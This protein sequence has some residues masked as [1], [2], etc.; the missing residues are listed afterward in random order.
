MTEDGLSDSRVT[1]GGADGTGIDPWLSRSQALSRITAA[2]REAGID[3][4]A[5]DARFLFLHVLGITQ[6]ELVLSGAE[7]LGEQGA[8]RL[9]EAMQRRL[10][11]EP[12]A[13]I[14]G[15]W[16]FWGLPFILNAATLVPR[17]DT[18]TMVDAA[19]SLHATRDRPLRLLDLGT[20]SGCILIALL[21][22]WT[23]AF[24]VGVDRSH[25]ALG[26]ARS[27]ARMN[28]VGRRAAFLA[29]DWC[30]ALGKPFDVIL[31]NPPYIPSA[32]IPMLSH[33]VRYH[34]PIGALDGGE[35]GLAAYRRITAEVSGASDGRRL[36]ARDGAL[37][38]E[39]GYDQAEDVVRIGHEAGFTQGSI[40]HDLAGHARV[41]TL[42]GL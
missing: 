24:G 25:E 10:A 32:T 29:G 2:F 14:L 19:L 26:C 8:K 7:T 36:L 9:G 11:G 37:V 31:S 5:S 40:R 15:E 18:E 20:G 21:S 27:N 17:P 30:S 41:V 13:R 35:D 42:S 22:E 39:V 12:V 3:G 1:G 16:E 4:G 34:D 38:F 6:T 23:Q 28:G 33:E